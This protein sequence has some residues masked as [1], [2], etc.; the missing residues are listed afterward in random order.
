MKGRLRARVIRGRTGREG[1]HLRDDIPTE[2]AAVQA[3]ISELCQSSK[4]SFWPAIFFQKT[5]PWRFLLE[6]HTAAECGIKGTYFRARSFPPGQDFP[7]STEFGPPPQEK[8]RS[9]RYNEGNACILYLSRTQE[10]AVFESERPPERPR[11][12][13][14]RFDLTLPQVRVLR[15]RIDLEDIAPY[16]H[17]LLLDSEYIPNES[18]HVPAPYKA[19]HFIAFLCRALGISGVEF[20]SV[21]GNFKNNP[22][23]INL[24]L[25]D[26]CAQDACE[27]TVGAPI[28]IE[29]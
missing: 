7:R 11:L 28:E 15:L 21:R 2:H 5:L 9:G 17:Y 1:D 25:F 23:A 24:V 6:A 20:P 27:M 29:P 3:F 8:R 22:E 26:K 13:V 18:L 19:T 12:F 4:A 10:T 16:L 14:Q